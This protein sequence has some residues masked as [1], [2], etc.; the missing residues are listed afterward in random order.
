LEEEISA[1]REARIKEKEALEKQISDMEEQSSRDTEMYE[2]AEEERA[3]Y[4]AVLEEQI[5]HDQTLLDQAV[6]DAV[7]KANN[8]ARLLQ[9][10]A[11]RSE[12]CKWEAA[13][14]ARDASV[15]WTCV[16]DLAQSDLEHVRTS[17]ETLSAL[18]IGLECQWNIT[19][20]VL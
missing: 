3:A 9:E 11:L 4:T 1:L 17:M 2:K 15:A 13:S 8:N 20:A 14:C 6:Q 7:G 12:R 18:L 19:E 16:R 10:A 5:R